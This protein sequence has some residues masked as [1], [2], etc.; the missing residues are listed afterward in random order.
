[1]GEEH[2]T[3]LRNLRTKEPNSRPIHLLYY[4]QGNF[5]HPMDLKN[6]DMSRVKVAKHIFLNEN[7][8]LVEADRSHPNY[9]TKVQLFDE[10]MEAL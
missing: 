9:K 2:I 5:F 4:Y 3:I 6:K 1:M 10:Q 7:K 8:E